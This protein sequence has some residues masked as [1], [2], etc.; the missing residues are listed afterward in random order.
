MNRIIHLSLALL[1]FSLVSHG[2]HDVDHHHDH[3]DPKAA[4]KIQHNIEHF[5]I[6]LYKILAARSDGE[7]VVFSPCSISIVLSVLLL[8]TNSNTHAEILKGLDFNMTKIQE[9]EIHQGFHELLHLL[10]HSE[11]DYKLDIGQALFLKEGIQPLQTFLDKIKEFYEAEIQATKF[12]DPKEAEKQINDYIKE[13]THGKIAELVKDLSIETV[14]VLTNYIFFR[15]HWKNPFNP[16][17][18]REE[19]FFVDHNTTV[20]VQM[21][22]RTGWFYSYFDSQLSCTVLQIDYNGTE[23][24]FFVLPDPKKEKELDASLSIE[25]VNRWAQNVQRN[26]A[27]VS[28]PKFSIS[29]T[30]NLKEPLSQLGITEIFTDDADLSRVTGGRALKLSKAIHKAV[31][32]IDESG[33][34]A[35]GATAAELMPVSL[36]PEHQFNHPFIVLVFNRQINGTLFAAKIVNPTQL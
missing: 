28:I 9:D 30:Y 8:G 18:T 31:L 19:D 32:T 25:T 16:E 26:T 1:V 36:P 4:I 2:H 6:E 22:H 24:T 17:F 13:K 20:K 34:E 12:Q 21:M 14:F 7:N 23:T 35:A 29:A 10:T 33:T 27:T 15:G 3:H 5:A 11:E